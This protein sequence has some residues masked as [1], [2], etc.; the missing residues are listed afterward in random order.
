MLSVLKRELKTYFLTPIGYVFIGIFLEVSSLIFYIYTYYSGSLNFSYV[1]YDSAVILTF[2]IAILTMNMFAGER[3][4]GTDQLIMTSPKSITGIV[5]GKFLAA[6]IV[7]IITE[8][9]SCMYL[10]IIGHFGVPDISTLGTTLLGFILLT[11]AYISF[12]ELAS[13]ITDQPIIAY[14]ITFAFFFA[15][16]YIKNLSSIFSMVSFIDLYEKFINGIIPIEETIQ[17]ITFTITCI[18]LTII[19][20]QRRKNLK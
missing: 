9:F 15:S 7:V 2:I 13:S 18:I 11:M 6:I 10:A 5:L 4:N 14:I 8:I 19:I 20:I 16:M 3:K 12:G 1:F 17:L